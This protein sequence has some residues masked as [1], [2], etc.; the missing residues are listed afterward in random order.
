MKIKKIPLFV[1]SLLLT[2]LPVIFYLVNYR[3]SG[4]DSGTYINHVQD[5]TLSFDSYSLSSILFYPVLFFFSY[6]P[7]SLLVASILYRTFFVF[8]FGRPAFPLLEITFTSFAFFP[9][10]SILSLFPGKDVFSFGFFIV[11]VYCILEKKSFYLWV[12]F[13]CIALLF[14]PPLGIFLILFCLSYWLFLNFSQSFRLRPILSVSLPVLLVIALLF[15][16]LPLFQGFAL[17]DIQE[18][19]AIDVEADYFNVVG[20]TKLPLSALNLFF[21]LMS[22]A[23]FSVYSFL[24]IE[25]IAAIYFVVKFLRSSDSFVSRLDFKFLCFFVILYAFSLSTLWPN[26]TDAARKI[27]PLTFC[28]S[29]A[30]VLLRRRAT[31]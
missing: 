2:S 20:Y 28:G 29:A 26:V 17:A 7:D 23:P 5:K 9:L 15:T 10:H 30:F 6:N 13:S 3:W 14:R 18:R 1:L 19:I 27:Y 21:P 11:L 16:V 12:L 25:N 4:G 31:A 24:S 22:S 8:S